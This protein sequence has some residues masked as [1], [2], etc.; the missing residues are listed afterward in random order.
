MEFLFSCS[1][2]G[3]TKRIK[4]DAFFDYLWVS[5][6]NSKNI[7]EKVF[8]FFKFV[9]RSIFF[10]AFSSAPVCRV[11]LRLKQNLRNF[12][13]LMVI[14]WNAAFSPYVMTSSQIFSLPVRPN[15]FNKYILS[16]LGYTA[17]T[18]LF[19]GWIA[20]DLMERQRNMTSRG[21]LRLKIWKDFDS[22][23][24]A[25]CVLRRDC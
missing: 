12:Q 5:C 1:V 17:F 13:H 8:F 10:V 20:N 25:I 19:C 22:M 23:I 15:S 7:R 3:K 4:K 18:V 16:C 9:Y 14:R 21:T 2:Q 24:Y 11:L 6:T